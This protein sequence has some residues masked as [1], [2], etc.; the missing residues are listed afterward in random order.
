MWA[1]NA[2]RPVGLQELE[3]VGLL[4]E[5]AFH[6]AAHAAEALR[7]NFPTKIGE[8]KVIPLLQFAWDE[9]L[10]EKKKEL[11]GE[12][13]EYPSNVMCFVDGQ[14]L[15]DEKMMLK[16]AY[17]VWDYKDFKPTALYEAITQDFLTKYMR[18]KKHVFVFLEIAIQEMTV[19]KLLFELYS[20]I[21]PRTCRNFQYLCTGEKMNSESGVVLT[22]QDSIFH[23]IVKNGWI[24]GGDIHGGRGNGGESIYGPVFEDENFAVRHDRR[25]V[26][27]MA[28]KGRHS[29]GSQF[30]ITLQAAPYLNDKYVAFGQL[31]EGSEV[32]QELEAM[33][34]FNERPI[35][36]CKII[37]CGVFKP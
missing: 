8:P 22:Y 33:E 20:D 30:Y 37:N 14:L 26:L 32:L 1:K 11:R 6:M 2:L 29:N 17:D 15:G 5:P 13:W 12:T 25:G 28:N 21:C 16:W 3:V 7:R 23:R 10:Q 35:L 34:T 36:E 31:L 24:Q 19:G 4:T 27:G 9:Y 18:N